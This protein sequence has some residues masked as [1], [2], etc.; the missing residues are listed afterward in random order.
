MFQCHCWADSDHAAM[1]KQWPI[2][3][4]EELLFEKEH[5]TMKYA[6]SM[7]KQSFIKLGEINKFQLRINSR[8]K[9][10]VLL[11]L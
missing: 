1:G 9:I 2:T 3:N 7:H 11:N 8:L 4:E 10:I 5:D 6:I